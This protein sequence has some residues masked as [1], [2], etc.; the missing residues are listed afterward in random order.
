MDMV[1]TTKDVGKGILSIYKKYD[2]IRIS[3]YMQPQF[4]AIQTKG[5]KSYSGGDFAPNVDNRFMMR[6]GRLRID[7]IHFSDTKKP[8]VQFVFQFDGSEKG[9]FT[10][11]FWGRIM[12]N[13][14]KLFSF[15][16]GLFARPFG[17][18]L[19]LGSGDRESPERGRMSQSLMKVERDL[20]AM[21]SFEPRERTNWLKYVKLDAGV[22]NGPGLTATADYDSY[23]DFISRAT[24]KPYPLQKNLSLS[25]GLSYFNGGLIQGDKYYYTLSSEN[26]QKQFTID[27]A[28]T[29]IG[30]KLPRKYYGIDAQL[31]WKYK[32][33]GATEL[34]AEYWRG[35]QTSSAAT[36]ETPAAVF[37]TDAYYAR[38]FNGAFFYLLHSFDSHNQLGIKYDWYD[39][40]TKLSGD[41]VSTASGSH[42]GDIRY[43]T[44]GMGYIHYFDENLKLVAWYEFIK[45][46]TT[47]LDGYTS[48]IKDNVLTLRL[49][50]K[51]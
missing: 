3:G 31:K 36:S 45:N 37:S 7:Y 15:T 24:L 14:T 11:D 33:G 41:E 42:A 1:D 23:K 13:N 18:E 39:P 30:R 47:A 50:F 12:E 25:A 5:A 4:Q 17:Y 51:F 43:N 35:T 34:R 38:Q 49:Q 27:S 8:S 6:R 26:G 48:D 22:F 32:N 40:N 20:G 28:Q 21:V 2:H 16:A 46:E 19:N 10:R 9:F 44:L 29:N